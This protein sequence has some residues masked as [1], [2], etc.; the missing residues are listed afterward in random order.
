MGLI[1][2]E[3]AGSFRPRGNRIFK[4]QSHG[5]AQAVA[6][7]IEW[8]SAEVLPAAIAQDHELQAEGVAPE[9]GYGPRQEG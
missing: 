3:V 9:K 2:V 7:A 4:A 1:R 5:H 8:L 6:A